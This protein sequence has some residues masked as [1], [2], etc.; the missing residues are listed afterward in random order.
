MLRRGW[1]QAPPLGHRPANCA[2]DMDPPRDPAH[3]SWKSSLHRSIL[4][5]SGDTVTIRTSPAQVLFDAISPSLVSVRYPCRDAV[6]LPNSQASHTTLVESLFR[7]SRR[8]LASRKATG[9]V[10][11]PSYLNSLPSCTCIRL[12]VSGWGINIPHF[13]QEQVLFENADHHF[14]SRFDLSFFIVPFTVQ[15]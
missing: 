1:V 13:R 8:C 5:R 12:L 4:W 6:S 15:S 11:F 14:V 9:G 10:F 3:P 2:A 7:F